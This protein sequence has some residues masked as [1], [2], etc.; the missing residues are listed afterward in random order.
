MD[1]FTFIWGRNWFNVFAISFT[2]SWN[3]RTFLLFI[4]RTVAASMASW[5][6]CRTLSLL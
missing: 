6:S 5:R 3:C 1:R 2:S 4:I